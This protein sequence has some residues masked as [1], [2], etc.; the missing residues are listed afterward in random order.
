M[1]KQNGRILTICG[2]AAAVLAALFI[3]ITIVDVIQTSQYR[4][5][6][7]NTPVMI[8]AVLVFIA[9]VIAFVLGRMR[10]R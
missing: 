7:F 10:S 9:G 4:N 2:A 1:K 5:V 8:F 6:G 3:V